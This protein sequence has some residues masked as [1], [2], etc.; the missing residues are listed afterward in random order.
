MAIVTV[1]PKFQVV[2]PREIRKAMGLESGQKVQVL[3]RYVYRTGYNPQAI[4]HRTWWLGFTG[5]VMATYVAL[6]GLGLWLVILVLAVANGI[7]REAV[8]VPKLGNSPGLILS[9]I[10][11]SGFVLLVAYV[12]LPWLNTQGMELILIGLG[13]LLA[14]LIFEFSFGLLRGKALNEILAAYTFKGGNIWPIVLLVVA[15][16]PWVAGK[17][18]GR[19]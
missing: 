1:S 15:V 16:A 9:G 8:L 10:L 11:L 14:T 6:R 19:T 12:G 5:G 3:P 18:R 13:W 2:I 7:V 4:N 17:L